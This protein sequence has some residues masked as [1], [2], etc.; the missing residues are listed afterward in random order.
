MAYSLGMAKMSRFFGGPQ[1][2]AVFD[3][4]TFKPSKSLK[5]FQR[6]HEYQ[7]SINLNTDEVIEQ[8]AST[9]CDEETWLTNDMQICL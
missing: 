3:P 4:K 8:C 6:K 1:P 2:R 7:V 9:R 5:K